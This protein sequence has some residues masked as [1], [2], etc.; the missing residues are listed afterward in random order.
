[1][2][3]Q[4][5]TK[6]AGFTFIE[7][8]TVVSIIA[9]LASF[10]IAAFS[11]FSRRQ[12]IVQASKE[13]ESA[14]KD[15]QSRALSSVDGE[16]WG[17]HFVIG[18]GD[19]ELFSSG[20]VKYDEAT[21]KLPHHL[22]SKVTIFDPTGS[23]PNGFNGN[24]VFSVLDGAVGFVENGGRCYGGSPDFSCPSGSLSTNCAIIGVRLQGLAENRYL[25]V[26]ERSIYEDDDPTS[27][28]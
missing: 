19:F 22:A 10:S 2:N 9:L 16:N 13:I 5:S 21:Q 26:Y 17:V 6:R 4:P 8:I 28:P 18:Q 1:M 12:T 25:K 27:C 3:Y 14:L 15:A 20:S 23:L 11:G 24:I 7:I